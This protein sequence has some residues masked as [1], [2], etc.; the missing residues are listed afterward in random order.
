MNELQGY[1]TTT[2]AVGDR[3]G[4]VVL[5]FPRPVQWAALDPETAAQVGEAMARSAYKCRYGLEPNTNA[6][7]IGSE[8]RT[9]LITRATHIIRSLQN[10][11]KLPGVVAAEVVDTILSEVF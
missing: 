6:S 3:G 10:K 5:S 4:Q 8:V 7:M 11:G 2:V 1:G 9:R